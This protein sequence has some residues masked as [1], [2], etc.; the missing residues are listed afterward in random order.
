MVKVTLQR[1]GLSPDALCAQCSLVKPVYDHTLKA[2]K[3]KT[4]NGLTM[5]IRVVG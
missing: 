4:G 5:L 2:W 3:T 1:G